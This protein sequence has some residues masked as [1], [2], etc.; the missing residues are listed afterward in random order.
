MEPGNFEIF[1]NKWKRSQIWLQVEGI[2]DVRQWNIW[3]ESFRVLKHGNKY[4]GFLM[5]DIKKCLPFIKNVKNL[6][7][8]IVL[9]EQPELE[10]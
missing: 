8:N 3:D 5:V 6:G 7:D 1:A 10:A 4:Y 9:C 2:E